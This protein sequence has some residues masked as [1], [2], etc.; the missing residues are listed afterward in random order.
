MREEVQKQIQSWV[1]GW[2]ETYQQYGDD[3]F[4][5]SEFWLKIVMLSVEQIAQYSTHPA[6]YMSAEISKIVRQELDKRRSAA[7]P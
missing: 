3:S 2:F 4:Q 6:I 1:P 7:T 5:K